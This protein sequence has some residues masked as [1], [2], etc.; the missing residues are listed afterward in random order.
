MISS[1]VG[2]LMHPIRLQI[3]TTMA[4]QQ[5]TAGDLSHALAIPPTTLYR[6][7]NALV[8]GGILTIVEEIQKRGTVERV[9]AVTEAPSLTAE[10][11]ACMHKEDYEQIFMLY[12]T[13]LIRDMQRYLATKPDNSSFDILADGVELSKVRLNLSDD[14][15]KSM[16][17]QITALMV[18]AIE[19]QPT[20]DRKPRIFTFM[21]IPGVGT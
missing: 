15:L 4:N 3:V 9:Y 12:L 14:E 8:E 18:S 20:T 19:N 16:N 1:K 10:D 5:M 21:F 7:I 6:H 13:T 11:L 17:N 2:L